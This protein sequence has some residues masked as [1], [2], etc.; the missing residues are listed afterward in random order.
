MRVHLITVVGGYVDV[1]PFMLEHY[2]SL[3]IEDF[4]V[5]VHLRDRGDAVID[6]VQRVTTRFGCAAPTTFVGDWQSQQERVWRQAMRRHADDWCVLADQDELHRYPDEL[7]SLLAYCDR[8]GYDVLTGAFV[9][10]VSADGRFPAVQPGQPIAAQFPCG[11]FVSYPL[12]G[13]DPRKV[14]AA[15]GRVVV[16]RGQ[17]LALSGRA[18]PIDEAFVQVHHYKWTGGLVARLRERAAL[19]RRNGVAHWTESDRFVRYCES[20]GERLDLTDPRLMIAP[21]APDYPYWDRLTGMARAHAAAVRV[22]R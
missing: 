4:L 13:A 5:N 10:R 3:G 18:C 15:K 7:S 19:L 16:V 14:V 21:C 11:G 6:E 1:L 17:H 2:R 20:H 22:A 8:H 12:L 9:D